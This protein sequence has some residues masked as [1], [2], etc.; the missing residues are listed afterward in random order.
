MRGVGKKL[1]RRVDLGRI[2]AFISTHMHG[3][4]VRSTIFT[5]SDRADAVA[6]LGKTIWG[7]R[8]C[9]Q[10]GREEPRETLPQVASA[11]QSGADH[12]VPDR[13]ES[14]K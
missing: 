10:V 5:D 3:I 4:M 11:S 9:E 7:K 1:F 8:A 2:V 12:T 14:R 13:T 6:E